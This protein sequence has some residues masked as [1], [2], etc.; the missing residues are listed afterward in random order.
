MFYYF[1]SEDNNEWTFDHEGSRQ[2]RNVEPGELYI[3]EA[4]ISPRLQ[5]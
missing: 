5:K 3:E 4:A 1:R 2:Y